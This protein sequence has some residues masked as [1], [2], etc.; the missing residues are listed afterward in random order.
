MIKKLLPF[1]SQRNAKPVI[2][3]LLFECVNFTL[4]A[5]YSITGRK[6]GNSLIPT[7]IREVLRYHLAVFATVD[8]ADAN[9]TKI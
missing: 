9:A 7:L 6:A 8:N 1:G 5:S 4:T 2:F 3:F